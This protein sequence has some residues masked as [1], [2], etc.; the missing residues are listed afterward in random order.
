MDIVIREIKEPIRHIFESI[1]QWENDEEIKPLII[2]RTSESELE[3]I[4]AEGLMLNFVNNKFKRFFVVFD[5][6]KPIGCFNIDTHFHAL[7]HKTNRTAWI[8]ILIGDKDYWGTGVSKLMM[9][10]IEHHCKEMGMFYIELGVFKFNI[11][12]RKLY[13]TMGFREVAEIPKFVYYE[14]AWHS[15]VRML[16]KII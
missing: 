16:K 5:G 6:E 12:A 2:P 15:D 13:K 7:F 1:A 3:V 10:D 11:R 4:T 8:S 14:G 9:M